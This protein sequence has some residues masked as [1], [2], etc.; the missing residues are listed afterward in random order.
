MS[1][2]GETVTLRRRLGRSGIEVS[3]MGLG[4]WAIGGMVIKNGEPRG[5]GAVDD[6]E[7]VRAVRRALELG[8]TFFDTSDSYGAGRSEKVL[9]RALKGVRDEVVLATKFGNV[10]D[11]AA[12]TSGGT[13]GSPGYVKK[14]CEASLR[15]LETD[16]IDLYQFHLGKHEPGEAASVR[17]ALEEMVAGGRIRAYGWSTDSP[18]RARLFAEGAHCTAIQQRLNVFQGNG[19]TLKVCEQWDLASIN[20]N[21]LAQGLL[22]GKFGP[23]TVFG[24]GDVRA[25]WDLK[26]GERAG[27]LRKLEELREALTDGGRTLAQGALAWIWARSEVTVPIPGFKTVAQAEE[28]AGA[29]AR[30]P[31]REEQMRRIDGLLGR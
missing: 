3:A 19:E 26:A 22:T 7:S 20:R 30:G 9:G 10:F 28:N 5:W 13:D 21:P 15:R 8:V 16:Y 27:W 4:C 12:G 2:T 6:A 25:G 17:E 24:E 14:A 29:M 31:L 1:G 23:E 18:E 11:E